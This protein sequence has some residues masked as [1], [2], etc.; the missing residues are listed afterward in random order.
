MLQGCIPWQLSDHSQLQLL[1]L[2]NNQLN[3]SI[4]KQFANFASMIEQNNGFDLGSTHILLTYSNRS[5]TPYS[6][7]INENWKGKYYT[8]EKAIAHMIG[9]DMSNNLLSGE[10]PAELTNLKGLQLLN[11]SRNNLSG[12]IPADIGNLKDLESLDLSCNELSGHIPD[13]L[14]SLT[15]LS[16]LNLSNNQL[17]GPIP[18]DGQLGTLNDPSIYSNN[19]GL[20]GLPLNIACRN[21]S[22]GS[23]ANEDEDSGLSYS[24]LGGF[25]FRFW[26]WFGE[27]IFYDPWWITVLSCIDRVLN[28]IVHI[29]QNC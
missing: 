13:S 4:P 2:A 24:T 25:A 18:R 28:K 14:S 15:F 9:I 16:S 26:L 3:G 10:I 1:D 7:R 11:L 8:F 12:G 21:G 23:A 6:D 29:I 20:C 27:L 19:S 5:L 22:S 17:S